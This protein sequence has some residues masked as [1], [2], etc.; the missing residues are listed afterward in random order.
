M[1]P[2]RILFPA[3]CTVLLGLPGCAVFSDA[4]HYRGIAV[5]PH[6]LSELTPG[7]SQ[8]ADVEAVLGPPTFTP[9]FDQND[10]VYVS[11]VTKMRIG[12]TEGVKKQHVVIVAF[13]DSGVM[14]SV[15]EKDLKDAVRVPMDQTTT[16]VPGGKAGLIQQLIGGV[17]S[18]NPLGTAQDTSGGVAGGGGSSVGSSSGGGG[19]LSGSGF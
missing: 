14:Q 13:N 12:R 2:A 4:P 18:Y 9:Q 1:R 15:T 19:G 7:L 6:D 11:Q 16:P 3:L 5:T 17:G 10:W 8:Q